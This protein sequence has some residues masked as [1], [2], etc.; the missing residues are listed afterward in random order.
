MKNEIIITF[1]GDYV[2]AIANGEKDFDFATDLFT[3]IVQVC[4]DNDCKKV[5]GLANTSK[6][7][8][9]MEAYQMAEL[10]RQ[11]GLTHDYQIAWVELNEDS[12]EAIYFAET[13]LVN[14]GL[15]VRLFK[16]ESQAKKWL[17]D[18]SNEV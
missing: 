15:P 12:Y 7:L 9:T 13:V 3:Q 16:D 11:L 1:E 10:F 8:R 2:Q 18:D 4:Q 5:L 17:L 6:P 14:R